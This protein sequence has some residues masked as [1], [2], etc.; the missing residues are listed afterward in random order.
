MRNN[1]MLN[2]N[3]TFSSFINKVQKLNVRDR[4]TIEALFDMDFVQTV[5]ERVGDLARLRK[6]NK[7]LSL[8]DF[9][10]S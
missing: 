4:E 1:D 5:K 6:G 7:L 9:K 3:S 2:T 8:A 10:G